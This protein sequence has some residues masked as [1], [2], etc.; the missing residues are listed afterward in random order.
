MHSKAIRLI[1]ERI[2]D[3]NFE[4]A[5]LEKHWPD[6]KLIPAYKNEVQS[7]TQSLNILNSN[8]NEHR[9]VTSNG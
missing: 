3:C 7:L 9:D 1:S 2:K 6:S 5:M 8:A 4:L